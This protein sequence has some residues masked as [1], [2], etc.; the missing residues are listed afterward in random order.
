MH[1]IAT[2]A[3]AR[4]DESKLGEPKLKRTQTTCLPGW[5]CARVARSP[6]LWNRCFLKSD[7]TRLNAK[8]GVG[9]ERPQ[10]EASNRLDAYG[11][12][13]GMAWFA[14]RPWHGQ[15]ARKNRIYNVQK[16]TTPLE[17][18][19]MRPHR[20]TTP[21]IHFQKSSCANAGLFSKSTSLSH[22]PTCF[23]QGN[24]KSR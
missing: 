19:H 16:L 18:S 11:I 8:E 14:A 2:K 13:R 15:P 21:P 9:R 23:D 3:A 7:P 6:N 10:T 1:R 4:S 22:R 12:R 5:N 24:S 20:Y 17:F